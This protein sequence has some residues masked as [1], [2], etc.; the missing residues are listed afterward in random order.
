MLVGMTDAAARVEAAK[1]ALADAE[2]ALAQAQ[3]EPG[4]GRT[5]GAECAS[6]DE[7]T[8]PTG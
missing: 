6:T 1:K 5:P 8:A 7:R 2:A 4:A 3:A